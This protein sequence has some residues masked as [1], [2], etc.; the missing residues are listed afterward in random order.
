MAMQVSYLW[1]T[2]GAPPTGA[3]AAKVSTVSVGLN[4]T[5]SGDTS[6][7]LTHAFNLSNAQLTQ[8]FPFVWFEPLDALASGSNWYL[9]SSNP[10]FVIVAR[11]ATTASLDT[12]NNVQTICRIERPWSGGK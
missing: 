7:I 5:N 10:N 3:L 11:G 2:A 8:G 1:P 9:L 12:T 6:Q 4:P